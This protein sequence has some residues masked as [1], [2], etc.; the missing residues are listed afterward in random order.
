MPSEAQKAVAVALNCACGELARA[1]LIISDKPRN[2]EVIKLNSDP[3]ATVPKWW[4]LAQH[5]NAT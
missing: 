5:T 4:N 1:A 2:G 3:I